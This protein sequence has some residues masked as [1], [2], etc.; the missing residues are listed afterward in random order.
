MMVPPSPLPAG[1]GADA[2]FGVVE[3]LIVGIDHDV[4]GLI[5]VVETT[6]QSVA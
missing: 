3:A 1:H 6:G 4:A 2:T 5:V